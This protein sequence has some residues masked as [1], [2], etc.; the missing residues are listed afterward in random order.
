MSRDCDD[1]TA[2]NQITY[3]TSHDLRTFFNAIKV[4]LKEVFP[5]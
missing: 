4:V 1:E 3:Y 5:I 2:E